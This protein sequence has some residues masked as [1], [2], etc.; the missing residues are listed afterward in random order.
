MKVIDW[1]VVDESDVVVSM[2]RVEYD[3]S[4]TPAGSS[5]RQRRSNGVQEHGSLFNEGYQ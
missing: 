1:N 2:Q 5:T 4:V 3:V